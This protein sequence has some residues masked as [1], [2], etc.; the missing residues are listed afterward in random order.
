MS[1]R[2]LIADDHPIVRTGIAT[3]LERIVN[4]EIVG[5][6][7]TADE[8]LQFAKELIPDVLLL[9]INMPGMK[10]VELLQGIRDEKISTKVLIL[11]AFKDPGNVLGALE[12]GAHGYLLKDEAPN[13]IAAAI[14]AIVRNEAWFSPSIQ[15][16]LAEKAR[17]KQILREDE[18]T[19][20]EAQIMEYINEGWKNSEIAAQLQLSQRTV[21]YHLSNIYKKLGVDSRT[22]AIT[23][24]RDQ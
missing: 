2:I 5:K 24:I 17:G 1:I 3:E 21:E 12:A 9:D 15:K 18:F 10:M 13:N 8:A 11:T 16:I 7:G 19:K 4:F 14:N 22:R 23:A 6:A 20:R